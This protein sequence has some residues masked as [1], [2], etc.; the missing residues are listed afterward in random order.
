MNTETRTISGVEVRIQAV[1]EVDE[2]VCALG[3]WCPPLLTVNASLDAATRKALAAYLVRTRRS[4]F[5]K[6]EPDGTIEVSYTSEGGALQSE[7]LPVP[8]ATRHPGPSTSHA[9]TRER[10]NWHRL[11]EKVES[12]AAPALPARVEINSM[13][14]A[15]KEWQGE[16][17]V[18]FKDIDTVHQRPVG[19]AHRAF[20]AN[21]ERLMEE[22]DYYRLTYG[23]VKGTN[24]VPNSSRGNPQREI[25]AL[26]ESGYLMLVK[27][28]TDDLSWRVQRELVNTYFKARSPEPPTAPAGGATLPFALLRTIMGTLETHRQLIAQIDSKA[29]KALARTDRLR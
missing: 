11:T 21:R 20:K 24:F 26:T 18:T 9:R 23:Q 28:F 7:P 12:L 5:A 15:I 25:V 6:A 14:I 10:M 27:T 2:E 22:V 8:A 19:T 3:S 1:R 17:V 29:S 13:E 16:R 4:F